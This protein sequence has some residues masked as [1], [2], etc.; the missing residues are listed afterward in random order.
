MLSM[1]LQQC[2]HTL[3]NDLKVSCM[4]SSASQPAGTVT[5]PPLKSFTSLAAFWKE[6]NQGS[7]GKHP[8]EKLSTYDSW[9]KGD[10]NL[11]KRW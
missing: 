4:Q 1:Q 5:L 2:L 6:C 9:R 8:L 7:F 10:S 11:Q 3:G